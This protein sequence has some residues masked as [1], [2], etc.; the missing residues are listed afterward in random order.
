MSAHYLFSLDGKAPE[1]WLDAFPNGVVLNLT[2]SVPQQLAP[3]DVLWILGADRL[4]QA[5]QQLA[6]MRSHVPVV[7][8]SMAPSQSQA[9]AV[10][11]AGAKGYC[12]ALSTPKMLRQVALVVSHGGLW[13]GADL[14]SRLVSAAQSSI[15]DVQQQAAPIAE[16][17]TPRERAVADEVLQGASN[18]EAA[19][20]LGI[21]ERTVKAHLSAIFEKLGVRD[22]LQ[23]ILTLKKTIHSAER[24]A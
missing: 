21:T 10:L 11:E 22:R 18:K 16:R 2:S 4:L 13:V 12:H 19:R 6:T 8:L 24:A 20:N 17:L 14:V 23:L 5:V 7:A 3:E 9:L 1:R 15:P